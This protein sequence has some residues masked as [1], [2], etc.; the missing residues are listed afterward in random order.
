MVVNKSEEPLFFICVNLKN[1]GT[2]PGRDIRRDEKFTVIFPQNSLRLPMWSP[3]T[4]CFH[5]YELDEW[6][7]LTSIDILF[8]T[9]E[10]KR[11]KRDNGTPGIFL[12]ML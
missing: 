2:R 6:N 10:G 9:F 12:Q 8:D 11:R 5:L 4:F 3:N 7:L 1:P